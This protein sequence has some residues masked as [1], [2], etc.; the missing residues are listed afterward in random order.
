MQLGMASDRP[1]MPR[2]GR[3]DGASIGSEP[4]CA[5]WIHRPRQ[6]EAVAESCTQN[7]PPG[8]AHTLRPASISDRSATRSLTG[9]PIGLEGRAADIP[10]DSGTRVLIAPDLRLC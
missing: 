4:D 9:W 5:P 8:D 2:A 1:R 10:G 7:R 6:A 3:L